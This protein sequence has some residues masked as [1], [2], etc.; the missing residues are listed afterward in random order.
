MKI[1]KRIL[2]VLAALLG[3]IL[4]IAIFLPSSAHI[5]ESMTIGAPAKTIFAKVN[6]LKA[7]EPWSPFQKADPEM[8]SEYSGPASGEG[9]MQTWKS[10]MHGNGSLTILESRPYEFIKMK[11]MMMENSE[12]LSNFK[13]EPEQQG[14]KVTWSLDMKDLSYPLGRI[15]ALFMPG[16]VH[17]SFRSGLNDLKILCENEAM[18]MMKFK[19]GE[20]SLTEVKPW[21]GLAVKDSST[22]DK[23]S[24]VMGNIFG[25]VQKHMQEQ[26]IECTGA[27]YAMYYLWDEKANKFVLEAGYPVKG[28]QKDSGII[29]FKEYPAT[30]AVTAIHTGSYETLYNSYLA[31]E[32][33]IRDNHMKQKGMPWEVYL[34][35]PATQPDMTK[36]ETQIYYP[37]E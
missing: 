26:K 2:I 25:M 6:D 23:V 10:D 18:M 12:A 9:C 37:V 13:F 17:E 21:N 33:Y 15:F 29:K 36:W 27:P 30:K 35:D 7:W 8:I 11:L 14:T 19:T 16:S 5:E 32:K 22:T 31:L 24:D 1:F 28:K 3:V 4:I 20:I 34:T